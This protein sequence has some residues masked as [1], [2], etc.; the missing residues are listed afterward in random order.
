MSQRQQFRNQAA[1]ETLPD[2]RSNTR[3]LLEKLTSLDIHMLE[4]HFVSMESSYAAWR[5][6]LIFRLL[7]NG[8]SEQGIV[9]MAIFTFCSPAV[10]DEMRGAAFQHGLPEALF[11]ELADLRIHKTSVVHRPHARQQLHIT[12]YQKYL[13]WPS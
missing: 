3:S 6:W 9:S 2:A 5:N 13:I 11:N 12:R 8:S 10:G 4:K 7:R 1:P